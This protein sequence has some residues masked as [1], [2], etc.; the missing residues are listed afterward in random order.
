MR[1]QSIATIVIGLLMASAILAQK[2]EFPDGLRGF[3]SS[4]SFQHDGKEYKYELDTD[5]IKD[6]PSWKVSDGEPPLTVV[7]AVEIG[8]TQL[9]KFIK[10]TDGWDVDTIQLHQADREKWYYEIHF[11]CIEVGCSSKAAGGFTILVKFDG[12]PLEPKVTKAPK[13]S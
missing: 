2:S 10:R 4:L 5:S 9:A 8:K 12:V 13:I 6:T 1:F 3:A 7:R 11:S